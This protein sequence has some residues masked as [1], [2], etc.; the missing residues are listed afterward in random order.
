MPSTNYI[1]S[2]ST[3]YN[4]LVQFRRAYSRAETVD[5]GWNSSRAKVIDNCLVS[6]EQWR[7]DDR[8]SLLGARDR[9]LMWVFGVGRNAD[10]DR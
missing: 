9:A 10:N 8:H 4:E 7:K 2:Q 5:E 1:R 6:L 3:A